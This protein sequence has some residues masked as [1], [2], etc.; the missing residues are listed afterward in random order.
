M[1]RQ[2]NYQRQKQFLA[3]QRS[4]GNKNIK[5]WR[6]RKRNIKIKT[7]IQQFKNIEV[8]H[9]GRVLRNMVV[10]RKTIYWSVTN[11]F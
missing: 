7:V 2:E 8:K 11:W 4:I 9:G 6:I 10:R 3:N 5:N 1:R